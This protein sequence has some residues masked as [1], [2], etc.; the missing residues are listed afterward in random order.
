MAGQEVPAPLL[1]SLLAAT[2][3]AQTWTFPMNPRAAYLHLV[4]R[5]ASDHLPL[6]AAV[7]M[8]GPHS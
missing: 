1:C 7:R 2:A 8:H 4:A 3:A 6:L 5:T